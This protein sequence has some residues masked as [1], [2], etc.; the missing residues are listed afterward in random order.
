MPKS[1]SE[2]LFLALI[3]GGFMLFNYVAQQLAKKAR[4]QQ[5]AAQAEAPP[6]A[7]EEAPPP[8]DEPLEDIWGRAPVTP[9][10][11]PAPVARTAPKP[12]AAPPLPSRRRS[13]AR[14]FRTRKDLRHAIVL[15][16]VLGPC[17]ALEP[18]E[19]R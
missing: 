17:R 2:L 12:Q 19:R 13:G 9:P 10:A 15:M 18:H 7:E 4:E 1:G 11:A 14:L 8:G 6:A 5:Q 16:T 3:I